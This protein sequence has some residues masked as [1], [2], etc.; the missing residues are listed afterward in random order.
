VMGIDLSKKPGDTA[1]ILIPS[2]GCPMGCNFCSTSAL[3]GGK[4]KSIHFYETGDQL[5]EVMLEL[6]RK[7]K[8]NSF[9]ALDEN[10]LFHKN[11]AMRLLELMRKH[12]KSWAIFIFSSAQILKHYTMDELLGL[13]VSWVWMGIEGK[14]SRYEKLHNIDTMEL[15]RKLQEN[16]IRVLGSS[17]IGLE[18][19][20]AENISEVIDH[21][22]A[23]NTVFHQFMLYTPTEG[24]PFYEEMK[25]KGALLP[26][27]E[28]SLSD[29]NG[30]YRL[31]Y[32]HG[33]IEK[34]KEEE[35]LLEAFRRDF[36]VNGPSIARLVKTTFDGY[37]KHKDHPD[38]RIR[39]R[40]RRDAKTLSITFAGVIWAIRKKFSEYSGT[41]M[42]MKSLLDRIYQEFG[43]KSRIAAPIAGLY[44]YMAITREEKRLAS[45]WTYEPPTFYEFNTAAR[46]IMANPAM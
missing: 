34:G 10:F 28:C 46:R 11:R 13:G 26:E 15:V 21:A 17:I 8:V 44:I 25:T 16:G 31:N 2:V 29:A 4:G 40:I 30:Q 12:D 27:S 43:F 39:R 9:F 20:S 3:F 32:K 22:V 6:E 14:N 38:E 5:F 18:D 35:Y 24:T 41:E 42:E 19:H 45:G 23:H 33:H 36:K 1:A 7:L 37:Q